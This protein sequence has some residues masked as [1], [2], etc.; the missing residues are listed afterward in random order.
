M[1]SYDPRRQGEDFEK[2]AAAAAA[3]KELAAKKEITVGQLALAWLL[4]QRTTS[5]RFPA[6]ATR[7][8]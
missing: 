8:G 6:T 7:P 3:L 5:S 2:G 4:A 1:P